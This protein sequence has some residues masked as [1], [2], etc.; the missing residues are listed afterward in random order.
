MRA[1]LYTRSW[2]LC[3]QAPP[4][5][6]RVTR[7]SARRCAPTPPAHC[8]SE[9]VQTLIPKPATPREESRP[10]PT[11]RMPRRRR[12]N[13]GATR[14]PASLDKT[15]TCPEQSPGSSRKLN[16]ARWH[17]PAGT[18][19]RWVFPSAS[20]KA[21]KIK[22]KWRI[23]RIR[24]AKLTL[25]VFRRPRSSSCIRALVVRPRIPQTRPVAAMNSTLP[26]PKQAGVLR[27][28]FVTFS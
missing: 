20:P 27:A 16:T 14:Q 2:S 4:A 10:I 13:Q 8:H 22:T 5:K 6:G 24:R 7:S 26:R 17:P 12:P 1:R 11:R 3:I 15:A 9:R 18:S 23:W 19:G 28:K 21:P 25:R